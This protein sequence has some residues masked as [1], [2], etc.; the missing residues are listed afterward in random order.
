[1]G[2]YYFFF[3]GF[4]GAA[5][6]VNTFSGG[7]GILDPQRTPGLTPYRRLGVVSPT[8]GLRTYK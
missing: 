3:D 1:M 5:A 4:S 6:P 2:I 8:A 7:L